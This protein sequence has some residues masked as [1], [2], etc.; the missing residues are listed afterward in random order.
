MRLLVQR[1]LYNESDN[2]FSNSFPEIGRR[3]IG[4][5]LFLHCLLPFLCTGIMFAFFHND[6]YWPVIRLFSEI[7]LRGSTI[8]E[9]HN[10]IIAMEMLSQPCASDG[11]RDRINLSTFCLSISTFSITESHLGQN[12]GRELPVYMLQHCLAK[13]SFNRLALV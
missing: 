2:N 8:V 7:M 4:R 3:E 1:W 13:N 11:S 9:S 5:Y 12:S 6:G 10:L